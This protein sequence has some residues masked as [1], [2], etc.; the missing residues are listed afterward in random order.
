MSRSRGGKSRWSRL[1]RES[2]TGERL[3][4]DGRLSRRSRSKSRSRSL[5]EARQ[6]L[7]G[8]CGWGTL[9]SGGASRNDGASPRPANPLPLPSRGVGGAPDELPAGEPRGTSTSDFGPR[10]VSLGGKP[11][12]SVLERGPESLA[13]GGYVLPYVDGRLSRNGDLSRT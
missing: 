8:G 9:D 2:L 1:S 11:L 12:E 6:E 5:S 4:G 10:G 7:C 3:S 13:R